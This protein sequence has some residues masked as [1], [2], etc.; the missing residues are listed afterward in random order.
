M[1]TLA[2]SGVDAV[3]LANCVMSLCPL[4]KKYLN[5][6]RAEFPQITFVERTHEVDMKLER[7]F[8]RD[9]RDGVC[10]G[11]TIDGFLDKVMP[12]LLAKQ[13]NAPR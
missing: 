2:S 7:L 6:L 9:F 1:R 8:V 10:S 4:H 3:H 12:V 5:L 11:K 13:Q